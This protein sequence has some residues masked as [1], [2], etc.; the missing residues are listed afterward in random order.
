MR[1]LFVEDDAILAL[2]ATEAL[3]ILGHTVVG[4]A[5]SVQEALQFAANDPVDIAFVD[6]NLAGDEEGVKLAE[7]L[8]ENHGI[9]S[10]FVSG[11]IVAAQTNRQAALGLLPKPYLL[12][13]LDHSA[14]F[15]NALL[16]GKNPPP[17]E[18]PKALELF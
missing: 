1:I 17:P 9:Q 5:H 15:L 10:L 4:P 16:R 14:R 18:K 11:Q 12:E 13:D 2:M 6:I 3:T 7:S 8:M